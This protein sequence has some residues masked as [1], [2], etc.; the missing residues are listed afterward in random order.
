VRLWTIHPQYLDTKGLVALWREALLAQAVLEGRTRGYARH[1]QLARFRR[2]RTP[3]S[4]IACYLRAVH[5]E[6]RARGFR[7]EVGRIAGGGRV[8]RLTVRRG[9]IRYEWDHLLAK[10]RKRDPQRFLDLQSVRTIR[11]HPLFRIVPGGVEEW[12]IVP[13]DA[14]PPRVPA[15]RPK[16]PRPR[17]ADGSARGPAG[18]F[19][20]LA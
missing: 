20:R 3:V 11:P 1:P 19:R 5:A 15:A 16:P 9:Q 8:E 14:Q 18:P 2:A 17:D 13:G 4:A 10:L 7:F 6:G 12:E